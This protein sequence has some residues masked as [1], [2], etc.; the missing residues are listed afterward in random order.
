MDKVMISEF[1]NL[2]LIYNN[3]HSLLVVLNIFPFSR[4]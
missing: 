3:L 2:Q 1:H 4:E